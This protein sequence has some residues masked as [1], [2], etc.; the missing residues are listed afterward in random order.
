MPI[1][2][3]LFAQSSTTQPAAEAHEV[4]PMDSDFPSGNYSR[5]LYIGGAGDLVVVMAGLENVVT[6]KDI[7]AGTLLPIRV[8]QVKAATNASSIVALY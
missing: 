2:K 7:P 8:S 3:K 6:F 4:T 1:D 5:A